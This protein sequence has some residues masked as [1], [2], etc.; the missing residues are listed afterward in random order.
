[1][2][3]IDLVNFKKEF[4]KQPRVTARVIKIKQIMYGF[5]IPMIMLVI[6]TDQRNNKAVLIIV[7]L[8]L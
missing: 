6:F 3:L 1:M 4:R 7:P 8:V 2:N 5:K